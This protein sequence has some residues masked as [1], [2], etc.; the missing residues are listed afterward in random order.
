VISTGALLAAGAAVLGVAAAWSALGAL[1]HGL[2]QLLAAAGPD[3]RLARLLAPLRAGREASRDEHRRL[4]LVAAI[5]LLAGGWLLAGPPAGVL[6]AAAAPLLGSKIVEAAR[7]RRRDRL[8]S[9][10]PAV[11]R[12]LADALAGG[13]SVR[14]ALG[15]AAQG[16]VPEAAAAELRTAGVQLALGDAT[17]T[18]LERWRARAAHPAYDA[19]AAA[20]LLQREA[21]GDLAGLLR[22]LAEALEEQV[23]AEADARGLTAQARFTALIVAVLPLI[24]ALLAELASPGYLAGLIAAP[25]SAI[26]MTTSFALQ[27]L[28]WIAVRRIARLTG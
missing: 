22:G 18:V 11:A 15:E 7:R 16:G 13:H 9:A 20:I 10:A 28:A 1:D 27:L 21:G 25:L 2:G 19:L 12:A 3:G 26:L 24:G 6:L 4:I 5:G 23:R 14:A 17:E 8:A